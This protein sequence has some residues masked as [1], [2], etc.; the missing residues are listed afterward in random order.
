[1]LARKLREKLARYYEQDGRQ[2]AVRF[3]YSR[4]SYVPR[5]AVTPAASDR[6]ARTVAVLPFLNLSADHDAG[7]SATV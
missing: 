5:I 1:V 3:E 6:P 2:D 4:G 7:T